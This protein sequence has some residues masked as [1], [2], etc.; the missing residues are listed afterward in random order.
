MKDS[1]PNLFHHFRVRHGRVDAISTCSKSHAHG[2]WRTAPPVQG[3]IDLVT[4]AASQTKSSS[5][6]I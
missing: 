1:R 4:A 6:T 5:V 3:P 2:V